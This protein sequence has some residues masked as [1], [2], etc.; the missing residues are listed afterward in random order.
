MLWILIIF[1]YF[2]C[3]V[4]CL[5]LGFFQCVI[6]GHH[7]YHIHALVLTMDQYLVPYIYFSYCYHLWIAIGSIFGSISLHY[8]YHW[9]IYIGSMFGSILLSFM[10]LYWINIWFYIIIYIIII[11][12]VHWMSLFD[13]MLTMVDIQL[14]PSLFHIWLATYIMAKW[15]MIKTTIIIISI[16][17][18][19][20]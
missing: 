1:L 3:C 8:Y 13:L 2:A 14:Q 11:I 17:I 5:F 16:N 4:F 10:D 7:H 15:I 18:Y 6:I 20:L 12:Y 9:W 19:L